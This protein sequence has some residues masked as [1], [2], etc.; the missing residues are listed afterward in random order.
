MRVPSKVP[1][2]VPLRAQGFEVKGSFKSSFKGSFQGLSFQVFGF[3]QGFLKVPFSTNSGF[4]RVGFTSMAWVSTLRV[5]TNHLEFYSKGH[6]D[7][8]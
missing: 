6:T 7:D 3:L 8:S 2:K 4:Y 1:L 5:I